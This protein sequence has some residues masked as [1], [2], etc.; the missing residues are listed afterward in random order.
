MSEGEGE[1][2][3]GGESKGEVLLADYLVFVAGFSE[4][5]GGG[6]LDN[7]VCD[8]LSI[9][10]AFMEAEAQAQADAAAT[11]SATSALSEQNDSKTSTGDIPVSGLNKDGLA[12]MLRALEVE[13]SAAQL[14]R[15]WGLLSG[16]SERVAWNRIFEAIISG[17]C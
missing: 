9:F 3:G 6:M 16:G 13:I 12:H 15:V 11:S 5:H 17:P 2:G 4:T 10:D 8:I 1:G 14:M 7:V